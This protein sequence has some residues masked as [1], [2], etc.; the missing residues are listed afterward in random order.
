[1]RSMKMATS[2]VENSAKVL[3]CKMMLVHAQNHLNT[4]LR[5]YIGVVWYS[6]YHHVPQMLEKTSDS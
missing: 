3:S 1:M 2:K 6:G 5:K 4:P